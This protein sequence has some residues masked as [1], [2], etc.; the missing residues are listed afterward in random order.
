M[1]TWD[2]SREYDS[3][4]MYFDVFDNKHYNYSKH[5]CSFPNTFVEEEDI[6]KM[7]GPEGIGQ[8]TIDEIKR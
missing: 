8:K 4:D 5:T 2:T 7:G 1:G 6:H 3:Y